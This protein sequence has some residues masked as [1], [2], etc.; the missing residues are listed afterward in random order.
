MITFD[1]ILPRLSEILLSHASELAGRPSILIN[2]D[3]NSRVRLILDEK[4]K[5]VP[6]AEIT[7]S[8]IARDI[9]SALSPHAYAAENMFLFERDLSS[10]LS[11]RGTFPLEGYPDIRV[12][13]RL[14]TDGDWTVARVDPL[15]KVRRIVFYSIKGGVGRST[16]LGAVAWALAEGGKRILV[17]DLD[18]ESPGVSTSLLP[19]DRRPAYG[20][21]DWLVE[22]LVDNGAAVFD[23]IVASSE[24]S[25]NGEIFVAPAHG[26]DSGEYIAKLGRIWMPKID[27]QGGRET[28]PQR[29]NRLL[30]LLVQRWAPDVVLIDSRA[31]IDEVASACLTSLDAS[32][33]LLFAVDGDQTWRGYQTLFRHWRRTE[34]VENVRERLQ[35][36][37]AM[38]PELNAVEYVDTLREH[39]WDV[40]SEELYDEVPPGVL[41]GTEDLWS[42]DQADESAPHFP[43]TVQWHRGFA[44]LR[45]LHD[46]LHGIGRDEVERIFGPLI[47]GIILSTDMNECKHDD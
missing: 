31:G 8:V 12:I 24:L 38:V 9:S 27:R 17:L 4:W 29:L 15:E 22:D 43:W 37:G 16:A 11:Q 23:D 35:I 14:P 19:E 47:N 1:N 6:E 7:L 2:R 25:R 26:K 46:R 36:V 41:S 32:L 44:A 13:D 40:F 42:F 3:L 30:G 5:C 45:N 20:I 39:A 33:I 28:W 34:A 18:L 21:T 10:S